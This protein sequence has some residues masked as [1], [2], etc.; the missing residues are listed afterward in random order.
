MASN[1]T[2]QRSLAPCAQPGVIRQPA[3]AALA[4]FV[5]LKACGIQRECP[6]RILVKSSSGRAAS[7]GKQ[8][9]P[10]ILLHP[11]PS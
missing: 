9:G 4:S 6:A 2:M 11:P 5:G 3:R 7:T 8:L 1:L 10:M